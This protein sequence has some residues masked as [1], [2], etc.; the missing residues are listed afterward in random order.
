MN[1]FKVAA[2]AIVG[3]A[4]LLPVSSMSKT[5]QESADFIT[6]SKSNTISLNSQVDGESTTAIISQAK[7]LDAALSSGFLSDKKAPIYLFL[8]TPGGSIQ[9][10]LEMI[11]ALNGIGRPVNTITLFAAS[12]GFQI[13]QNLG[14]RLIL[15]SGILMS[16]RASGGFEGQFGGQYP[17]QIDSRYALWK[18]RLDE[19]DKQTVSRTK[20]KQTLESYQKQYASEMWITGTQS[21]EQGYADRVVT[22]KCDKTLNGTTAHE[23][24]FM[25]MPVEYE[26]DNCPINT[27]P[28]RVH[29][30]L[31]A[32]RR[33]SLSEKDVASKTET[34]DDDKFVSLG[35]GFGSACLTSESS[36]CA[37]DPYLTLDRLKEIKSKFIEQFGNKKDKVVPMLF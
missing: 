34:M 8:N 15:K 6:L 1:K 21:V 12:M 5:K 7:D 31:T 37:S 30:K 32:L 27:S 33:I 29:L 23:V 36:L 28:I 35:G 10:G 14:D 16:H 11:E 9:S 20:G 22:I 2:L 18:T 19:M 25:G 17:S 13:A 26:L 24:S 3:V 4:V